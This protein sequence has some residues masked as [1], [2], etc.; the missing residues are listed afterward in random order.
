[1]GNLSALG[2]D[3]SSCEEV[4]RQEPTKQE[5]A[6]NDEQQNGPKQPP[7]H[8]IIR[9]RGLRMEWSQAVEVTIDQVYEAWSRQ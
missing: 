6:R 3:A 7:S 9:W 2:G 8:R 4:S 1:M 5:E